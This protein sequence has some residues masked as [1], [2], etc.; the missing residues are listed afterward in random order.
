MDKDKE[1][2]ERIWGDFIAFIKAEAETDIA[3][4]TRAN[5]IKFF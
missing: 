5:V 3:Y 2:L 1:T 4:L